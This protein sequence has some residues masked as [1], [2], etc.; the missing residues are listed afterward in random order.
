MARGHRQPLQPGANVRGQLLGGKIAIA[1]LLAQRLQQDRFQVGVEPLAGACRLRRPARGF[2]GGAA[3]KVA[4]F[5]EL[6]LVGVERGQ[7]VQRAIQVQQLRAV[8][9]DP[10]QIVAERNALAVAAAHLRLHLARAIDQ[11]H[12]HHLGG[13]GVKMAAILAHGLLLI[14]EAQIKLVDQRCSLQEIG[15][16][17]TSDIGRGHLAQ[18]WINQRHQIFKGRR[19]AI[20]PLR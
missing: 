13:K 10:R 1:R 12:A 7:L 6:N 15:I 4:Q 5:D 17:L 8:N 11:D 14:Q 9:V 19:L 16:A 3:E 18:M 2:L 20:L